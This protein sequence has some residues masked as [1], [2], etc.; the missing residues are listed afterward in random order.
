MNTYQIRYD[1][2][3]QGKALVQFVQATSEQE[4]RQ[5][6]LDSGPLFQIIIKSCVCIKREAA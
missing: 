5:A 2:N 4:A 6:V 1:D 3:A